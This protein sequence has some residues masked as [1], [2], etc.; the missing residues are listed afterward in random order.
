MGPNLLIQFKKREKKYRYFNNKYS[1]R[2]FRTC[3][4]HHRP[5]FEKELLLA[6]D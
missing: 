1:F 5:N 3:N 4:K 6:L 2:I